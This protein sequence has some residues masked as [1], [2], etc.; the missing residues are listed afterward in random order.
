[1]ASG[2]TTLHAPLTGL[3]VVLALACGGPA[4]AEAPVGQAEPARLPEA[5]STVGAYL[6][7][8][9]A[10]SH[11][12]LES[13][14][15]LMKVV[16]D[17]DPQNMRLL[18]RTFVMAL[19]GGDLELATT[20]AD[21]V[22]ASEPSDQLAGL[23]LALDDVK[24]GRLEPAL[25][26]L[27][28]LGRDGVARF[29]LPIIEAWLRIGTGDRDGAVAALQ[30]EMETPGFAPLALL[31]KGLVL[32][33]AGDLP[34]AREAY[35]AALQQG[36]SVQLVQAL[37]SLYERVGERDEAHALYARYLTG[38]PENIMLEPALTRLDA[39][40]EARPLIGSPAEGIAEGLFQISSALIQENAGDLSL[41][42]LQMALHVQPDHA[43]AGVMLGDLLASRG[44]LQKALDAYEN[45]PSAS[46]VSW[47]ARL[48][49]ARV[50]H[51]LGR[52]D[53][54]AELLS[55]MAEERPD[56]SDPLIALGDLYRQE[57]R[58]VEA[59]EAYDRAAERSPALLDSDWSFSYRRGIALERAKRWERAEADLRRA[60]ELNPDHAHALNYLGYSW[61][62]RGEN[63][64]QAQ[65]MIEKAVSLMPED[66]YII[67]SL[68]WAYYR[69]GQFDRAVETLERAASLQPQDPV[70]ND[71]LGDAYAMVG[72]QYE[73]VYQW[74]R[75]LALTDPKDSDLIVAIEKKLAH[76][77]VPPGERVGRGEAAARPT[78]T[79]PE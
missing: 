9:F 40:G 43:L 23:V 29:V 53:E 21:R 33:W 12:D 74:R 30:A 45:V 35:E 16:L 32:D 42:Y 47:V 59:I 13:A 14:A 27:S 7:S 37:G 17:Q 6:A 69:T 34:A 72:R 62:D 71:H 41:A 50:L 67:D 22:L 51:E 65:A 39:G 15:R 70:I 63:L 57:E 44:E 58:F 66:G 31:H 38:N 46:P 48:N 8:N 76:G 25:D 24:V 3:A 52:P 19:G 68:G 36:V 79:Q 2:L 73:A 4:R 77:L 78:D 5:G 28:S 61:I 55:A 18:R 64:A 56:R 54:A 75:A 10:F 49:S 20:L 11:N 60:V 26:R 1:M